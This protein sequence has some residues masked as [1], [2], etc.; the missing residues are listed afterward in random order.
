MALTFPLMSIY[1][2]KYRR[3][4][5]ETLIKFQIRTEHGSRRLFQCNLFVEAFDHDPITSI[6]FKPWLY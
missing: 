3:P 2:M 4:N 6:H 1:H 5:F